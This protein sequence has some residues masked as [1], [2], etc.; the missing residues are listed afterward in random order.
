MGATGTPIR[1]VA[2]RDRERLILVAFHNGRQREGPI[3]ALEESD[4][5]TL[6]MLDLCHDLP[7]LRLEMLRHLK[8]S[9]EQRLA[10]VREVMAESRRA[11]QATNVV[12]ASAFGESAS[13]DDRLRA[14]AAIDTRTTTSSAVSEGLLSI[15]DLSLI[16]ELSDEERRQLTIYD[17]DRV[18]IRVQRMRPR[19]TP[20]ITPTSTVETKLVV[21]TEAATPAPS[22]PSRRSPANARKT[23]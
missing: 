5:L 11:D 1:D 20:A 21:E 16:G 13:S 4:G 9:R 12:I 22:S 23:R 18:S 7:N 8:L 15:R 19:A 3:R 10:I 17:L 6:L 14:I 2:P